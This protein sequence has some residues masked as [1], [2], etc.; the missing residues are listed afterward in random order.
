MDNQLFYFSG[1]GNCLK[2][3]RDLAGELGGA[4]ILPISKAMREGIDSSAKRIGIIFPVYMFGPPLIVAKFIKK[5]ALDKDKYIF[6]IATCGGK[7]ANSL[8]FIAR[9]LDLKGMKLSAGFIIKMPGNYTPLY[10][11]IAPDKQEKMFK[12]EGKRVKEIADIVKESKQGKIEKDLF[13]WR[14]LFSLIYKFCSP[15]IPVLDRGFWADEKCNGCSTCQKVCPVE[16]I[17]MI[18]QKPRWMHHCEQCMAC[19]QWCPQ[20][21]I[22]YKKSTYGRKRYHNPQILL[23]DL[24]YK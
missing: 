3:A 17:S 1:T 20:E 7:S 23:Q 12:D 21:A 19:L 16:N 2:V 11:A 14:W 22:Q 13:L 24:L 9:E 10:G 8:G 4:D 15:Q 5:L 18:E 6:A